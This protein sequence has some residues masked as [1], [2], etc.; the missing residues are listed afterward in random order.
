LQLGEDIK[1]FFGGDFGRDVAKSQEKR[2]EGGGKSSFVKYYVARIK[3][4]KI[5]SVTC[6]VMENKMVNTTN[7]ML[8]GTK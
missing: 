2:G 1:V 7:T 6:H 5:Y 4:R 8:L 3:R